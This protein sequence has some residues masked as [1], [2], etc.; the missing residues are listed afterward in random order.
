MGWF[1]PSL[2]V[3]SISS[4]VAVPCEVERDHMSCT[5]PKDARGVN[6]RLFQAHD[7]LEA[8]EESATDGR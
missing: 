7:S 6:T 5:E 1:M 3:V 4:R 2:N 8:G